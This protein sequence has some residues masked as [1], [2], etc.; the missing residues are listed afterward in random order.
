MALFVRPFVELFMD[1]AN[2]PRMSTINE[3]LKEMVEFHP[4]LAK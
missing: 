3:L 1:A 2:G 4:P